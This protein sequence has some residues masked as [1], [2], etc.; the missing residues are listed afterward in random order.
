ME[1][2]TSTSYI[3]KEVDQFKSSIE[4]Q[5]NALDDAQ[6]VVPW[7]VQPYSRRFKPKEKADQHE[8]LKNICI[9]QQIRDDFIQKHNH[10]FIV[11]EKS[12]VLVFEENDAKV[13]AR[14]MLDHPGSL[15]VCVGMEGLFWYSPS[16]FCFIFS[17]FKKSFVFNQNQKTSDLDLMYSP[18][19]SFDFSLRENSLEDLM[20]KGK[21]L[22]QFPAEE[23]QLF[24]FEYFYQKHY[25]PFFAGRLKQKRVFITLFLPVKSGIHKIGIKDEGLLSYF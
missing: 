15:Y 11:L 6:E 16:L 4:S 20:V 5:A 2:S 1:I 8:M 9:Y 3:V 14:Y 19:E 23:G 25:A 10:E 12:K 24:T 21:S 17:C 18:Q 13:S 22:V 7:W